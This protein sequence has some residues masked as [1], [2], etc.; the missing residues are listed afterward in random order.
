MMDIRQYFKAKSFD[1]EAKLQA[2]TSVF[3]TIIRAIEKE[4]N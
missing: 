2:S 3:K 1:L 4:I